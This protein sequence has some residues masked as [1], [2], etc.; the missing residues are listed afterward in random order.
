M[1]I[2][3]GYDI[4]IR[5]IP[6]KINPADAI[7]RQVKGD[8]LEYAGKV[9]QMDED[10]VSHIRVPVEANDGDIQKRLDQLYSTKELQEK[11]VNVQKQLLAL[12][13][14][15]RSAVLSVAE[16]SIQI[17]DSMKQRMM[18]VL[19]TEEQYSNILE[20]LQDPQ[21]AN[22]CTINDR[23]FRIKRGLLRVHE[24]NQPEQYSYWR[25]VVPD[26]QGIKLELLREIHCVPYSG[27][28]G[29][30]RTL[31][32]TRRFFYWAHMTQE[33]RQFVLDC[34]VCQ[35]EKGSHLKPAGKL[36][37]LEV[38]V[39]KWDHVV[40]DFVVGMPV[41]DGMDTICTVVD[42]ATK[43][44]HFIPCSESV[45]AKQVAKLYWLYVGKLHGIPSVLISDRDPRFTSRFWKELWRLLGT[46]LCMGSGF[47]PESSGQVEK[48]NQLLEQTLRCTVHQLGES[49]NWL[50][51]LPVI[52][53][54]VNNTPNRTTGYSAF[55]LNYGYHPLHPLQ[56]LHSPEDT[57]I[58]AVS[59][60]TS[61]MQK[62]FE[63]AR[64]QLN[65]ARNQMMHQTDS[66]RRAVE[67]Q[68]G[69]EV[70]LSTRH[71]RFRH[72]PTK[73]QRRYVGPFKVIQKV[74]RAAYRLQLPDNWLMHPVFHVSLLKPWRESRWSCP[75]EEQELDVDVEPEPRYEVERILKWRKVKVGRKTTRE[76]LVTWHGYPL[77][78]AQWIPETNFPYPSQLKQQLKDDRPVEDKGSTSTA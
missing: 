62:D 59:T 7:T 22:E 57:T 60:F 17:D 11:K 3:Q 70:L 50:D 40:L 61:R 30:T 76:F 69:D 52:E 12:K 25:S 64:Q 18:Q 55:Y 10:W 43:M 51:V 19:S 46:N 44:C 1:S 21:Q 47:H 74:N 33:V 4:E 48:F 53:F 38:P 20:Q 28:P 39:R 42:K 78:E 66:H 77:E 24:R 23:V 37:P 41:Q 72:C 14:E 27:H 15:E 54:A 58:E 36:L 49:R 63:V 35:V 45:S 13:Q 9:K 31:D 8:D 2:L 29:F 56:L 73:L 16:S 26:D 68:E 5:H 75:V 71:I 6:G 34:P 32:I 67:Y 65:Q